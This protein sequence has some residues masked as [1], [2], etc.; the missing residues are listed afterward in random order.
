MSTFSLALE[1]VLERSI[2]RWMPQSISTQSAHEHTHSLEHTER[3][4]KFRLLVSIAL[5]N[6]C[7]SIVGCISFLGDWRRMTAVAVFGIVN[8]LTLWAVRR[9]GALQAS[10]HTATGALMLGTTLLLLTT[11]GTHASGVWLMGALTMLPMLLLG[12]KEGLLWAIISAFIIIALGVSERLGVI[13]SVPPQ[14]GAFAGTLTALFPLVVITG[15]T[16]LFVLERVRSAERLREEQERSHSKAEEV[17][18]LLRAQERA[19]KRQQELLESSADLQVYLERSIEA[20]LR[21]MDNFAL[22]DLT[23]V[24]TAEQNDNIGRLFN[25]FNRAVEQFRSLVTEVA[26]AVQQTAHTTHQI[27]DH[28]HSVSE[29]MGL[30]TKQTSEIATVVEEMTATIAENARQVAAAAAEAAE[31]EEESRAGS[32]VVGETIQGMERIAVVVER[33]AQTIEQL[34]ASSESIGEITKVIDEIA[35]Q[36]N[37]L[38]LNAAIEAARAGAHGRGFAVVADEVRKLA[39]RTQKATKE[40]S[41]TVK[42]IQQQTHAAIKE[43]HYGQSEVYKG[44]QAASRANDALSRITSRSQRVSQLINHIAT[45]SEQQ[46]QAMDD[47][48]KSVDHITTITHQTASAIMET[49][50]HVF[51]LNMMTDTLLS[52]VQQFN[53]GKQQ[54]AQYSSDVAD[55]LNSFGSAAQQTS[56]GNGH[57]NGKHDKHGKTYVQ[58]PDHVVR[59]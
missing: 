17:Q 57:T 13:S 41:K 43:M 30:Q 2:A 14:Q 9:F 54:Q 16:L 23:V 21:E 8:I 18:R 50:A 19:A 46:S 24:V 12:R 31:A 59:L 40:I 47:I 27:A 48:A 55:L 52:L 32:A 5:M 1:R 26:D 6:C 28:S 15:I 22:G 10:V 49:T 34:G 51:N 29:G 20:I 33:A 7:L 25:G 35:D 45:A 58:P 4:F 36:T 39:E 3:L 37:L 53:T 56:N 11:G 38:A 44:Q 42:N